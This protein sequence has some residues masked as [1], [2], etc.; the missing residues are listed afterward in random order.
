MAAARRAPNRQ[1]NYVKYEKFYGQFH[2]TPEQDAATVSYYMQYAADV[3]NPGP[4]SRM[5]DVGC[6]WGLLMQAFKTKGFQVE[7]IDISAGQV[8]AARGRGFN[9]QHVPDSAAFLEANPDTYEVITLFDV[10]EHVGSDEQVRLMAGIAKALKPGGRLLLKSPS[11]YSCVASVM[12]YIDPTHQNVLANP[13]LTFLCANSNLEVQALQDEHSFSHRPPLLSKGMAYWLGYRALKAFF[14]TWRRLELT[15][16]I[17]G[18]HA[19]AAVLSP[20]LYL[21]ARKPV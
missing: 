1:E 15:S 5:L 16:E 19:A 11:A 18:E 6:G 7:G 10:L 13:V 9:V 2:G 12:R 21:I 14:R 4:T 17:G 3:P 8:A 20:N